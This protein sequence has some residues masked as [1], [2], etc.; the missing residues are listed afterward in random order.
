MGKP[1]FKKAVAL[2]AVAAFPATNAYDGDSA[3]T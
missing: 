3:F 2:T 1:V